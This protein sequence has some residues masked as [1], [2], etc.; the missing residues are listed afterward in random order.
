[1][2]PWELHPALVHFPIAWLLAATALDVTAAW[3][4]RLDLARFALGLLLAGEV[5]ALLSAAAGLLAYFTVPTHTEQAH[6][7]ML[8]HPIVAGSAVVLFGIIALFRWQHRNAVSGR[9]LAGASLVAAAVLIA[10][11]A[12]GGRLVFRAGV[13]VARDRQCIDATHE[14]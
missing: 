3:R 7:Q 10:G 9:A 8:I 1:M 5:A 2:H 6:V 11:G 12:L 14:H 4:Q 13:G